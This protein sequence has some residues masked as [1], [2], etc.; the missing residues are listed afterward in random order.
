[1]SRD[2]TTFRAA[3]LSYARAKVRY[4]HMCL[5]I[6]LMR[7]SLLAMGVVEGFFVRQY[8]VEATGQVPKKKRHPLLQVEDDE[9]HEVSF[10]PHVFRRQFATGLCLFLLRVYLPVSQSNKDDTLRNCCGRGMTRTVAFLLRRGARANV[11]NARGVT[12]L[13]MA[14]QNGRAAVARLLL[15]DPALRVDVNKPTPAGRTPLYIACGRGHLDVVRVLLAARAREPADGELPRHAAVPRDHFPRR[16]RRVRETAPAPPPL[17]DPRKRRIVPPPPP[18]PHRHP[19]CIPQV[20][21]R[22]A[23][24]RRRRR[25]S[26]PRAASRR[27]A[28]ARVPSGRDPPVPTSSAPRGRAVEPQ[29][30]RARSPAERA[31]AAAVMRAGYHISFRRPA[32]R[33]DAWLEHVMPFVGSFVSE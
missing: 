25:A 30:E 6:R 31:R 27:R 22:G 8:T 20:H 9:V 14:A 21:R 18:A 26:R 15:S 7:I 33:P 1:M 29:D 28:R 16:R 3:L 32:A 12:P 23:A 19:V 4:W 2:E 13:N 10:D 24:P 5:K 17:P 11:H